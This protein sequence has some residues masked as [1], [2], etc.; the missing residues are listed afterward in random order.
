MQVDSTNREALYNLGQAGFELDDSKGY[1]MASSS[2]TS[3]VCL[4]P[5]YRGALEIWLTRFVRHTGDEMRRV[6]AALE[7]RADT[8]SR[9]ASFLLLIGRIR[10]QLKEYEPALAAFTRAELETAAYKPAERELLRA[11]C[12]L[13]LADTTGFEEFY[14]RAL[15]E[16]AGDGDF[17]ALMVDAESIFTPEEAEKWERMKSPEQGAAFFRTFWTRRDPDPLTPFNERRVTHYARLAEA[18]DYF[19]LS[20]PHSRFQK[21]KSYNRLINLMQGGAG[22]S[23][24]E[25]DPDL[26][27][28][29]GSRLDLDPRG[30]LYVRHGQPDEVRRPAA[31][32]KL[33]FTQ[34]PTDETT[35]WILQSHGFS[36][37]P[38]IFEA[39]QAE[40]IPSQEVWRYGSTFFPFEKAA[41][42]GDFIFIPVYARGMGLIDKAMA[43]ESFSDP[44]PVFK[45]EYLGADFR[46]PGGDVELL[47][48]QSAA[49]DSIEMF[50]APFSDLAMFD[51][52]WSLVA[53]DSSI[54]WSVAD[55]LETC[56]LASNRLR[57]APGRYNLALR[58]DIPGRRA[59][60]RQP[61][62]LRS[63]NEN[64]LDLSGILLGSHPE[65]GQ[66]LFRRRGAEL[67]P[68]PSLRFAGGEKI[69][70]Y[71]EVYNLT[72]DSTGLG[73]FQ[74]RVTVS[75]DEEKSE[76]ARLLGFSA[77]KSEKSLSMVF[78]RA[79]E[80][81]QSSVAETFDIDTSPLLPGVYNLKV[82]ITDRASGER[83]TRGCTFE[84]IEPSGHS[85]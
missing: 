78:E 8:G 62:V 38:S 81:N 26:F 18:Q 36:L 25:Y 84:V 31:P 56:W 2:L 76:L 1:D 73:Q 65:R 34:M 66:G 20:N 13:A 3:L 14:E 80:K 59:V 41:G 68:R 44:L 82:E 51:S 58:L 12:R 22:S 69:A 49:Q 27:F 43:S 63:Y 10:Y 39:P 57:L 35:R 72:Q 33:Q 79:P 6:C 28:Q 60:R 85:R 47:F 17:E 77:Q 11:R 15:E 7:A 19:Y 50:N 29:R 70:V 52:T 75:R 32:M 30:L 9:T 55:R 74:E 61:M 4:D 71:L 16:A 64:S 48:F 24:Y 46:A 54:A 21:S 23:I 67:N 5:E 40:G 53:R 42:A 45:Q 37:P 83:R